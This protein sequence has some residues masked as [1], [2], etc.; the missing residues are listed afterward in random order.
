MGKIKTLVL[1]FTTV[2]RLQDIVD[3]TR[4]ILPDSAEL[5]RH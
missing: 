2:K 4:G 1:A 3:A 5:F